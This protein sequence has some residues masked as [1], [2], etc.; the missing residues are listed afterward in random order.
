[1]KHASVLFVLV[2]LGTA[3]AQQWQVELVDTSCR[4]AEVFV[5]RGSARTYVAYMTT[6]GGIRI[7]AKD[8]AW[9]YEDMDTGL[10]RPML[11]PYNQFHFALGPAGRIA[12][13]GVD[14]SLRPIVY[15][16]S[17][18]VWARFWGLHEPLHYYAPL[19]RA[20]FGADS[21]LSMI[22]CANYD[23]AA[24]VK[25]V[26]FADSVWQA[27]FPA[28]FNPGSPNSCELTLCDAD[29]SQEAGVCFLIRYAYGLPR[30]SK[31][32][33]TY[34]VDKGFER[35]T[36]WRLVG[37]G[38]GWNAIVY[39]YDIVSDG[40]DTAS[41]GVYF[42]G[43]SLFDHDSVW[44]GRAM[45]A[46]VQVDTAGRSLMA[47]VT[48]DSVLRFGFKGGFW[49]FYEVPGVT[50][51]TCCD[52]ALDDAGQPLIAFEDANGVWLAHGIDVV[53]V[54]DSHMPQ[55][56]IHKP[57]ATVLSGASGVK[58]LASSVVFDA[59]GR[60]VV[61]PRSGIYFVREAQAQAV[62]RV[63]ITE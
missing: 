6:E 57:A 8:T 25:V 30:S 38:G 20:V 46:A 7:A 33:W 1:M 55:A 19:A 63:V 5:K 31:V 48:A 39:G 58:R 11:D 26:T 35:D 15:V 40:P 10:V 36:G 14:D 34:E 62:R 61:N 52:L 47:F 43:Y 45:D 4:P 21:A 18:S 60:R 37:L 13:S 50:T 28:H 32:P 9:S 54:E 17:E 51:A 24:E 22:Y 27:D 41:A 44:S 53:G 42:G 23:T 16:K 3:V 59:T 56:S 2:C 29:G 12:V 49:H